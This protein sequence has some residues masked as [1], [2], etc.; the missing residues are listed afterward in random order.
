[1]LDTGRSYTPDGVIGQGEFSR[2]RCAMS[3]PSYERHERHDRRAWLAGQSRR[4]L[5]TIFGGPGARRPHPCPA[6]YGGRR[7]H[8]V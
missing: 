6:L 7:A 8:P 3:K 5:E 4:A 1:M 2:S